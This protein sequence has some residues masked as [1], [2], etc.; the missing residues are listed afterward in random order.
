MVSLIN[1][2]SKKNS[3]ELVLNGFFLFFLHKY[4]FLCPCDK[5][6]SEHARVCVCYI[7]FPTLMFFMMSA[8]IGSQ[9]VEAETG[10][11]CCC[12]RNDCCWETCCCVVLKALIR[13]LLWVVLV[14]FDGDWYVC[15]KTYSRSPI[16]ACEQET[17]LT[18]DNRTAVRYYI[19]ESRVSSPTFQISLSV[20][21]LC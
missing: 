12:V 20:Y 6:Y 16:L 21:T 11:C 15:L 3:G 8:I 4:P 2:F 17:D 13:A 7:I 18:P 1:L 9:R 5:D 14:L 10:D 19:D